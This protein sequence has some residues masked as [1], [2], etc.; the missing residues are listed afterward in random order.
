MLIRI[1]AASS[2]AAILVTCIGTHTLGQLEAFR[3]MNAKVLKIC[4]TLRGTVL[5]GVKGVQ[6][7]LLLDR[8]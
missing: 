8:F 2:L 5:Q 7:E 3:T 1:C 6:E 4:W